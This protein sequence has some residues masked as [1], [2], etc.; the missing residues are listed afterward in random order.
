MKALGMVPIHLRE[1]I[2]TRKVALQYVI[3]DNQAPA[4]LEALEADRITSEKYTS[5]ME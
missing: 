2:E 1:R 5:L 4:R 3:R